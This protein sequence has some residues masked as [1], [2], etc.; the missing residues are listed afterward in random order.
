V[1][2]GAGAAGIRN[3]HIG[4]SQVTLRQ[5]IV[6]GVVAV[7]PALLF[8]ALLAGI[9]WWV[10]LIDRGLERQAQRDEQDLR[11]DGARRQR[12][13]DCRLQGVDVED[14]PKRVTTSYTLARN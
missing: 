12:L 6:C 14:C 9:V 2:R 11:E 7:V 10:V 4:E 3:L 8:V 1:S 13:E 5:Q